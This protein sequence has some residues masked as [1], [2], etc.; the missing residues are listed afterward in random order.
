MGRVVMFLWGHTPARR[1]R[2]LPSASTTPVV[3]FGACFFGIL[4]LGCGV[5]DRTLQASSGGNGNRAGSDNGSSGRHYMPSEGGA[6]SG[7][8]KANAPVEIPVCD[9]SGD[10]GSECESLAKNAGFKSDV[11]DWDPD[12]GVYGLWRQDD[13]GESKTSGS[14]DVLNTLS[15]TDEGVA[16]GSARQCLP[17]TPGYDYDLASD[18]FIEEGQGDGV[19]PGAPYEGS[20]VLGA[21]FFDDEECRGTSVGFLNADPVATT[22]EWKHV[23]TS[24]TAPELTQ[25]I[26]VRLNALKPI[27]ETTFKA[28]FDNVFVRERSP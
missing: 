27:R 12:G 11:S 22:G 24:G 21:F 25:S 6:D 14:I 13:A 26:S 16:P 5:D 7:G 10:V 9:Y 4:A 3:L 17:A 2:V 15:G 28:T 20:A 1:L 19:A 18:V 23:S 8:G